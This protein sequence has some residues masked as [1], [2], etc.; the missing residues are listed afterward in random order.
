LGAYVVAVYEQ[1]WFLAE[2]T[3][4]Q[5]GV[6]NG[7]TQLSYMAIKGNNSFAW[8]QKDIHVALNEDILMEP[9]CPEP[10][11]SRGHLGLKK[12]DL[13]KVI[14]LMV[15]VYLLLFN[16][17]FYYF[18]H[19]GTFHLPLF[20]NLHFFP[21]YI[22]NLKTIDHNLFLGEKITQILD[23]PICYMFDLTMLS[24]YVYF[25]TVFFN[26]P[27]PEIHSFFLKL[28]QVSDLTLRKA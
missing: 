25:L 18:Q 13:E 19:Y 2:I 28:L 20:R 11:N 7:Y 8:G 5:T 6:G 3:K 9:V 12:I 22:L 4:D 21:H 16:Y 23:I 1:E 14:S 27:Y 15:V 17:S 10:I 24:Y 26:I